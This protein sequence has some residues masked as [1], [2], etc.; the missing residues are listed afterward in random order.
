MSK[1]KK[2]FC[3]FCNI[4]NKVDEMTGFQDCDAYKCFGC[5]N[6]VITFENEV[7]QQIFNEIGKKV[8]KNSKSCLEFFYEDPDWLHKN[9]NIVNSL[10]TL[11]NI[12][13]DLDTEITSLDMFIISLGALLKDSS[14]PFIPDELKTEI[15]D[16]RNMDK[17]A[18]AEKYPGKKRYEVFEEIY[19]RIRESADNL[20]ND[21]VHRLVDDVYE[22]FPQYRED[23]I[24]ITDYMISLL[25]VN[26]KP[27]EYSPDKF[28]IEDDKI[29]TQHVFFLMNFLN[30][31]DLM[32]FS[33][34]RMENYKKRLNSK[35][36]D[37]ILATHWLK[38]ILVGSAEISS[39]E[40]FF[41][42]E[43]QCPPLSSLADLEYYRKTGVWAKY[44][45]EN[46]H[47]DALLYSKL[48]NIYEV[49]I[50]KLDIE[51]PE[52]TMPFD[53]FE[54]DGLTIEP[55]L[56]GYIDE[57]NSYTNYAIKK[58][59]KY[60]DQVTMEL[61]KILGME[62]EILAEEPV[63]PTDEENIMEKVSAQLDTMSHGSPMESM[64]AY[65]SQLNSM[66]DMLKKH[67]AAD[68]NDLEAMLK[69]SN[70]YY[71]LNKN[72]ESEE[73]IKRA[74]ELDPENYDA[75]MLSTR[76]YI[77][78][79]DYY[80]VIEIFEKVLKF[81][82]DDFRTHVTL[83]SI[84]MELDET[85]KALSLL[86]KAVT[87]EKHDP[88]PWFMLG[89][90]YAKADD[91]E[92]CI[93]FTQK[94]ADLDPDN[95][96]LYLELGMANYFL[97]DYDKAEINFKKAL[98][99]NPDD[100]AATYTL[101]ITYLMK[102][103]TNLSYKYLQKAKKLAPLNPQISIDLGIALE[104]Q[105]KLKEAMDNY[106]FA[107]EKD[108]NNIKLLKVMADNCL[109]QK[110]DK[111]AIE[112]LEKA[113]ELNP[114]DFKT[115]YD[116]GTIYTSLKEY[117]KALEHYD[118]ALNLDPVNI[119]ALY[120]K[121]NV[122]CS[123]GEIDKSVDFFEDLTNKRKGDPLLW[124]HL[125]FLNQ[126]NSKYDKAIKCY[127]KS[128]ELLPGDPGVWLSKGIARSDSGDYEKAVD[129][130]KKAMELQEDFDEALYNLACVYNNLG[131]KEETL[132]YL[133]KAI[134]LNDDYKKEAKADKDFENL[135]EDEEFRKI[136]E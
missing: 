70:M 13:N 98:E 40:L 118:M 32:D 42:L 19:D 57:I 49:E 132:E 69:L 84:Y 3:I 85:D 75:L 63:Q 48:V 60:S 125:G 51:N 10:I 31:I 46:L 68:P 93:K 124:Y 106:K 101:G 72:E 100:T 8:R 54:R 29:T 77:D 47:L 34:E 111:K 22:K 113:K 7:F 2:E 96:V 27:E 86:E 18:F 121:G 62:E 20:L 105:G 26:Y 117:E 131:K 120:C 94:A 123:M 33:D 78:S 91:Y 17:S 41:N 107:L 53:F 133:K 103:K 59:R 82:P 12:E 35:P 25:S 66:I 38:N 39:P 90:I 129:D 87:I 97:E 14:L 81:W 95:H 79:M 112:Y 74:L 65:Y 23:L 136:T 119:D 130:I 80:K 76:K 127:D 1:R 99:L 83:A 88:T 16:L 36:S 135:V 55:R 134:A 15:A 126:R 61:S 43:L 56:K 114:E 67:I 128:L 37:P 122:Y 21:T 58:A 71:K 24:K 4:K 108:P 52:E 104:N 5:G 50:F 9:N 115:L 92:N 64:K 30:F 109:R 116:L 73:L 28:M 44:K 45:I 11:K 110:K 102:G 89:S 6:P